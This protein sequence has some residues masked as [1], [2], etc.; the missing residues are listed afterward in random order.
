METL[1]KIL[2]QVDMPADRLELEVT[3]TAF[4][5]E[6]E[7]AL[8]T[9]QALAEKGIRFSLDDFGM[10]YSSL[11]HLSHMPIHTLKIDK[12]FIH[13]MCRDERLLAI[14]RSTIQLGDNLGIDVI[15]EGVENAQE[16]EQLRL[17]NC[18]QV[19]GFYL[20]PPLLAADVPAFFATL[21]SA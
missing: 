17:L 10:G 21:K 8:A 6:P 20:S 2:A 19:Q 3:E 18:H 15:A 1:H 9:M 5:H 14:V 16:L 4:I 12:S 7:L 13:K 11:A